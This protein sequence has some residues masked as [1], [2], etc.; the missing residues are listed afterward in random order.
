[1]TQLE[2]TIVSLPSPNQTILK[3]SS[4]QQSLEGNLARALDGVYH[5][6]CFRCFD[7]NEPVAEKFFP[8]EFED[9]IQKPLCEKDYYKRLE[10]TCNDCGDALHGSYITAVGKKF[11][12]EHFRCCIC[13]MVLG[14][15]DSYY[16]HGDDV[17]CEFHYS[18]QHATKCAGCQCLILQQFVEINRN[19][20]DERWHPECYMI[21]KFWNVRLGQ[22]FEDI[23][24]DLNENNLSQMS[25]SELREFHE[26]NEE[27]IYRIWTILSAFEESAAGCISDMLLNFSEGNYVEGVK[28]AD[29]FVIHVDVLFTAIDKLAKYYHEEINE[30]LPY[31][32]ETTMLC[33]KVSNFFFL[34]SN[35]QRNETHQK[36]SITQD[37]LTLVTGL[38]QYLKV[39]IRIG[40][41][42]SLRLDKRKNKKSNAVSEFLSQ[43]M[44]LANK[45]KR[46]LKEEDSSVPSNLCQLCHKMC[47]EDGFRY[48]NL[49]W[50]YS[51]LSCAGCGSILTTD[52]LDDTFNTGDKTY[53]TLCRKCNTTTGLDFRE[54]FKN[55]LTYRSKLKQ[56]SFL[57]HIALQRLNVSLNGPSEILGTK[58]QMSNFQRSVMDR[59]PL[60]LQ[61]QE[62]KEKYIPELNHELK[63]K[64]E[65]PQE[66]QYK[67]EYS[68][69]QSL[70]HKYQPTPLPSSYPSTV[71]QEQPTNEEINLNDIKRM[72]SIHLNRKHTNSHRVGKRSTLMEI[73]SPTT[74]FLSN[75]FDEVKGTHDP[76]SRSHLT[77]VLNK[78]ISGQPHEF[79]MDYDPS[80]LSMNVLRQQQQQQQQQHTYTKPIP[81]A[82]SFYFAELG[83]LQHFMLK[84]VA[85]MYLHEILHDHFTLEELAGLIDEQ[86][87]PTFWGKFVTSLKASGRK[88][89]PKPKEGTFGVPIDILVDKNGIESN[90]GLGPTRMIKIPSFIDECVTAMK[91]MD[92]SVEGIFRKNGNIRRLKELCDDIDKNPGCAQFTNETPIQIAALIKKFLRELPDPLL[93]FKLHRLFIAAYKL[94]SEADRKRVIHLICCLLPKANRDT[95]EVLFIFMK[96]VAQFAEDAEGGGS[97]MTVENLATVIAPN[98]LYSKSKDPQ[99]DESLCA[100]ETV[101]LLIQNAEEFATVPEDFIPLLQNLTGE[102]SEL[103]FR[104]I[105]KIFQT[106]L[107]RN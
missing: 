84:R 2:S 54:V 71:C 38:A 26:K 43:L 77:T 22:T 60:P 14:P 97:K 20:I 66:H 91:Q 73:P 23:A 41:T 50:H 9:G 75:Q 57:L 106:F 65:L 21:H 99:K 6:K 56:S 70:L 13:T 55:D 18:I 61:K 78:Q 59:K 48:E 39:L 36:M 33:K 105:E 46:I 1:M 47:E 10:L 25:R 17:Y 81:K 8:F 11:H 79:V 30:N 98:I 3:C 103:E 24:E 82:K 16:E 96:W 92:M 51:C 4:C 69:P 95:M 52:Y 85:V 44:E 67:S 107:N 28:M 80:R 42:G 45:K 100:I 76:L 34:L 5:W 94:K 12:L 49:L 101:N 19:N 31:D 53:T 74:A 64:L 68:Y 89:V 72:K 63:E 83:T 88:K 86:Q 93:T 27:K 35:T 15:C 32:R 90:L 37:L 29:Y 58:Q 102:E 7:C 87:N 62:I 40:L 104:R